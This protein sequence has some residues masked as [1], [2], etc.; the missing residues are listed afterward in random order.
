MS[1]EAIIEIGATVAFSFLIYIVRYQYSRVKYYIN[2]NRK[3]C[4]DIEAIK[5]AI[6]TNARCTAQLKSIIISNMLEGTMND[7]V[8]SKVNELSTKTII[9]LDEER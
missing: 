9:T 7:I 8:T 3:T 5:R 4:E 2:S 6:N 1:L